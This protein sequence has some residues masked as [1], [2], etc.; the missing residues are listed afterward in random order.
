MGHWSGKSKERFV[1]EVMH[2]MLPG[3]EEKIRAM[4]EAVYDMSRE[5][6]QSFL[7]KVMSIADYVPEG[8]SIADIMTTEEFE[9]E[10][11]NPTLNKP[12]H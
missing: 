2:H 11:Y 12:K 5:D 1:A 7:D 4:T 9:R 8:G 10:L 3:D 6:A